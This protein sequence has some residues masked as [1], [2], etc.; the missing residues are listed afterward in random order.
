MA[1]KIKNRGA[2]LTSEMEWFCDA[3]PATVIAVTG[4]DG[5]T[6]TTTLTHLL[7]SEAAKR[8]GGTAYVGGNIGTPLLSRVSEMKQCDF[9]VL[10]LSS[11][12]LM[13]MHGAARRAAI[14]NITPNHLNWPACVGACDNEKIKAV[15]QVD[16]DGNYLL[17]IQQRVAAVLDINVAF[18]VK[19]RLRTV[20]VAGQS[21]LGKGEI[22]LCKN[23]QIFSQRV[24][25]WNQLGA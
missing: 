13:T 23:G 6:T 19:F 18:I 2:L 1:E 11:F 14:T 15:S 25:V 10:E 9:A 5:K 16:V 8:R 21:R 12:Q 4:S 3:T 7:L 20:V 17:R 24:R 22:Q